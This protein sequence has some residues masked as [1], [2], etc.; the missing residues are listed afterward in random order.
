MSSHR[1]HAILE[2]PFEVVEIS[3]YKGFTGVELEGAKGGPFREALPDG[4]AQATILMDIVDPAGQAM[5]EL[6]QPGQKL[7]MYLELE[8]P[9]SE[10]AEAIE[11]V[12]KFLNTPPI[13]MADYKPLIVSSGAGGGTAVQNTGQMVSVTI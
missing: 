9:Y 5:M 3:R 13:R 8:H 7:K 12:E 6:L 10:A 2:A 4:A 11:E 1:V